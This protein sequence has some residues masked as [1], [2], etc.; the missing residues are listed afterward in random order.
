MR[1][2][3]RAIARIYSIPW[4]KKWWGKR[5]QS[6]V[7]HDSP[8]AQPKKPLSESR[9]ALVSTA[10]VHLKKDQPFNMFDPNGDP[11]FRSIPSNATQEALTI[12]HDYFRSLEARQ[13]INLIFPI[14]LLRD[15]E[16]ENFIGNIT[17]SFYSFMGHIDGPLLKTLM[18]HT[19][20]K[21]IFLLSKESV[22][23]VIFVPG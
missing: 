13:D 3:N 7:N 23:I 22:D 16:Q 14:E 4:V 15:L 1:M 21:L 8:W 17:S 5:Y 6:P 20:K 9:V 19:S 2:F 18:E 10:G 11:S 12:T